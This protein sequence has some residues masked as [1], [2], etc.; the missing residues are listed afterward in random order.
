MHGPGWKIQ[1]LIDDVADENMITGASSRDTCIATYIH[2]DVLE[3]L[4]EARD[5][6]GD[7]KQIQ[8]DE[9]LGT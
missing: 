2:D 9:I 1:P 7:A 6:R 4:Y 5:I 8:N 3:D